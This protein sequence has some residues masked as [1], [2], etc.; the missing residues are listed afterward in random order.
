MSQRT[1]TRILAVVGAGLAWFP[2]VFTVVISVIGSLHERRFLFDFLMPAEFFPVALAG[3]ALLLLAAWRVKSR[4]RVI[5][6]GIGVALVGLFGAQGLAVVTGLAHG[7]TEPAGWPLFVVLA[8]LALYTLALVVVAVN[9][10]LLARDVLRPAPPSPGP[11]P[12]K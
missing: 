11:L 6:W 9:G 10:L 7:D 5:G 12:P 3:G 4:R 8:A 2:L 1:L